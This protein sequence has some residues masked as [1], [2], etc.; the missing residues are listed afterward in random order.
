MTTFN[1][2]VPFLEVRALR[3]ENHML[4]NEILP[5]IFHY[6]I[7]Q[8]GVQASYGGGNWHSNPEFLLVVKGR[9]KIIYNK[10]E[11]EIGEG[12]LININPEAFH[13]VKTDGK[14]E[15]FCLIVDLGFLRDNGIGENINFKAVVKK[16]PERERFK[17]IANFYK[18]KPEL[19][20]A[21]LRAEVLLLLIDIAEKYTNEEKNVNTLPKNIKKAMEFIKNNYMKDISIDDIVNHVGFSRAYFSREF[22]KH[23]GVTLVSYLNYIRCSQARNL[24]G[25]SGMSIG[26]AAEACGFKNFSYFSKTY[27]KLMGVLPSKDFDRIRK[28]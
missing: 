14:I 13:N 15:Y 20:N 26:A 3:Y 22:K 5:F 7:I 12:D 2:I 11:Y 6:D 16:A 4:E 9:G 27:Q 23:T 8:K 19:F 28:I 24:I 25:G 10:E 21:K 1:I 17:A 18:E